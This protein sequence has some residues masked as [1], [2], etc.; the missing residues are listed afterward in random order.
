MINLQ[1]QRTKTKKTKQQKRKN[2]K[3][4]ERR[5]RRRIGRGI[6]EDLTMIQGR[7]WKVVTV[8]TFNLLMPLKVSPS[9][10]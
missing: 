8:I 6:Y 9:M 10:L 1:Q 7:S 5:S 2:E 3:D 4:K